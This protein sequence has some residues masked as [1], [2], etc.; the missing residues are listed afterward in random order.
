MCWLW[1]TCE[2]GNR[3]HD[4]FENGNRTHE[5]VEGVNWNY[6]NVRKW[7][8]NPWT[9]WKYDSKPDQ[10]SRMGIEPKN[11][12]KVEIE[13][14]QMFKNGNR[15]PQKKLCLKWE[16]NPWTYC[17]CVYIIYFYTLVMVFV[18]YGAVIIALCEA[19]HCLF[20]HHKFGWISLHR[21]MRSV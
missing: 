17:K 19:V 20:G 6:T 18:H 12:L 16:S 21:C 1:K 4:M 8:S 15:T 2:S 7:E 11:M 5:F 9:C 3:T 14:I 13:T 10:C